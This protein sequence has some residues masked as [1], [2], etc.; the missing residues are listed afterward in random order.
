MDYKMYKIGEL[1]D[2]NIVEELKQ[3][4]VRSGITFQ[5]AQEH[6]SDNGDLYI[7]SVNY[8]HDVEKAQQIFN[9]LMGLA[10]EFEIPPEYQKIH[11]IKLTPFT[12]NL[13]LIC[14]SL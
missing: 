1:K 14:S 4:F 5:I 6:H 12:K 13:I 9:T 10:K 7:I 8:H 3:N 2:Y 11:S